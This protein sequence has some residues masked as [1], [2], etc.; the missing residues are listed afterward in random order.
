MI[1]IPDQ[2][3]VQI[4]ELLLHKSNAIIP[5]PVIYT[6]QVQSVFC[7]Q[8]YQLLVGKGRAFQMFGHMSAIPKQDTS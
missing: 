7:Y 8:F 1:A 5:C 2:L 6:F 3:L 4:A